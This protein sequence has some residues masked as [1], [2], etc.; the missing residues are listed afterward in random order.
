MLP[1]GKTFLVS[2]LT[3]FPN[4]EDTSSVRKGV[5]EKEQEKGTSRNVKAL[6]QDQGEAW[7]KNPLKFKQMGE[8]LGHWGER[9][10]HI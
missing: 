1:G 5:G 2:H 8:N 6:R 4:V 7:E 3:V 9:Q 10:E